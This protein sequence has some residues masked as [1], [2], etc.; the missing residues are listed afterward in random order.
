MTFY[1]CFT[2]HWNHSVLCLFNC[3][4]LHI[5]LCCYLVCPS[6]INLTDTS[7]V[8]T[9]PFYPRKYPDDQ[10]CFWEI[11]ASKG[12]FVKLDITDMQIHHC[13]A[14]GVCACDYLEILGGFLGSG[15][16]PGAA[17]GKL[18]VD[19][20][21]TPQFYYSTNERLRV[22]FF[23]NA[24]NS[25]QHKGFTATY[26]MLN[27]TPPGMCITDCWDHNWFITGAK[28]NVIKIFQR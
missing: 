26:T 17:S 8:I 5:I 24:L 22:R 1:H 12:N 18:C 15:L 13:G 21:F 7:G 20:R 28:Y 10:N 16:T 19:D 25:K 14:E 4:L 27:F 2:V 9:S 6:G 11:S 23:S 3:I